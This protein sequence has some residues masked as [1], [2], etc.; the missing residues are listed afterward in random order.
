MSDSV[1]HHPESWPH[2]LPVGVVAHT[3]TGLPAEL[4][5]GFRGPRFK[6]LNPA[7]GP[8]AVLTLP[9]NKLQCVTARELDVLVRVGVSLV[10]IVGVDVETVLPVVKTG[11]TA[12]ATLEGII[13]G[14]LHVLDGRGLDGEGQRSRNNSAIEG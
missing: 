7:G 11:A 8:F 1:A 3:D 12:R 13:P 10:L 5:S 14:K 2:S 4:L 9:W 6:R